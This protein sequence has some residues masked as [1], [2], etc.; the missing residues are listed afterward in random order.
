MMVYH[1][2]LGLMRKWAMG[3]GL[4]TKAIGTNSVIKLLLNGSMNTCWNNSS[5]IKDVPGKVYQLTVKNKRQEGG[6]LQAVNLSLGLEPIETNEMTARIERL[7]RQK[8]PCKLVGGLPF[9]RFRKF[10]LFLEVPLLNELRF[11]GLPG[12]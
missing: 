11:L 3:P 7:N 8:E 5:H 1:S 12:A 10:P 9:W 6:N 2:V 4:R